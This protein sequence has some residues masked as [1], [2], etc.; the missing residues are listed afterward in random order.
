MSRDVNCDQ[1]GDFEPELESIVEDEVL[2]DDVSILE[3]P[4]AKAKVKAT[5]ATK[6]A[7]AKARAKKASEA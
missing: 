5:K 6:A 1:L 4:K 7:T 2:T 3:K